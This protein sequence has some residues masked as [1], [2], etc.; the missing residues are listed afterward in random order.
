MLDSLDHIGIMAPPPDDTPRSMI[1]TDGTPW[2]IVVYGRQRA[3]SITAAQGCGPVSQPRIAFER[4]IE[5]II[6]SV[7]RQVECQP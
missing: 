4:G 7:V 3:D 1:C 6:G 2:R 5:S